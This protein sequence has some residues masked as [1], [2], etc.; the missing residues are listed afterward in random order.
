MLK[1]LHIKHFT[2]ITEHELELGSGLTVLTGETGAG[3]SILIDALGIVLGQR[4]DASLIQNSRDRC[5]V[6]AIFEISNIK[7]AQE[8]LTEQ[9]FDEGEE[10]LIRRVI[11]RDGRSRNTINGRPCTVQQVRELATLLVHIHGQNQHSL[12]LKA[13]YQ[14]QI[15]DSFAGHEDL[16]QPV[17][18][19]YAN[20]R[21]LQQALGAIEAADDYSSQQELLNFQLQEFIQLDLQPAELVK[22]N[23]EQQTL[24]YAEQW[25]M[26][27]QQVIALLA[28]DECSPVLTS[29]YSAK[30]LL[31]NLSGANPNLSA[32]GELLQQAII[33]SEEAINEVRKAQNTIEPDPQR[34][35]AI[36]Q[37]LALIQDL[38]R[39]HRVEPEAL[40]QKQQKISEQLQQLCSRDERLALLKLQIADKVAQYKTAAK[41]LTASRDKAA[42]R[43]SKAVSEQ[44]RVLGMPNGRFTVQ[45][46]SQNRDSPHP[47]GDEGVEFLVTANAGQPLQPLSKVVSGGEL[48]RISLAMQVITAKANAA[49]TL[50]FDEV[51]AGVGGRTAEIV[52]QQLK[53][54][55]QAAQVLCVTHL[56]QV[57][58]QGDLHLY[59]Q[60]VEKNNAVET[61][62]QPLGSMEKIAE[63]A[64]MLGGVTITEKTLA[65]AREMLG[66]EV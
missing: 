19:C 62:I 33:Q 35:T 46:T 24:A 8:W 43:L 1:H 42:Q 13:D 64:R 61:V 18:D 40:L 48:S 25:L 9:E 39:K 6:T 30:Q 4:A 63:I 12:L 14:R 38:A 47:Y 60:K 11:N 3:K 44:M 31:N 45:L 53:K 21:Q 22:L 59:I 66:I 57:A 34:L 20:W 10:C 16:Y 2:I 36:D 52:G 15:L 51:D 26:S 5:E 49:P 27:C 28:E 41:K 37:R 29:L 55:G 58:A 17:R 54:L 32:A 7:A 65:H 23:Q 56:P 50:I